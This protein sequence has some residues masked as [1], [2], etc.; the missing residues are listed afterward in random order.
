M[1]PR[2]ELIHVCYLFN[3][4]RSSVLLPRTEEMINI[5]FKE[6]KENKKKRNKKEQN[7]KI[8][9]DKRATGE[10]I[11][12]LEDRELNLIKGLIKTISGD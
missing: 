9:D 5:S 4:K 10:E 1:Q 2:S 11:S 12:A 3:N 6:L 8:H 7:G